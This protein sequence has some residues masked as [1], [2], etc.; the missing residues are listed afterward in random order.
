M[1]EKPHIPFVPPTFR[2][3][4]NA[5]EIY[6]LLHWAADDDKDNPEKV[7]EAFENYFKPE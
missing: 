4:D 1:P 2:L 3:G 6:E 7:L 5:Y